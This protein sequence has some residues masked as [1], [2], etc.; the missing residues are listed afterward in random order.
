MGVVVEVDVGKVVGD[1]VGGGVNVGLGVGSGVGVAHALNT[2]RAS[3]RIVVMPF[4]VFR[5]MDL[6][7]VNFS[8]IMSQP[9]RDGYLC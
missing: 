2:S 9:D 7:P 8:E 4:R 5:F 1:S 6:L 3:K